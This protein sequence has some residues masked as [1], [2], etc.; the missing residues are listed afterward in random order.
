[1]ELFLPVKFHWYFGNLTAPLVTMML[2]VETQFADF[3]SFWKK[4][5]HF[6]FLNTQLVV[7]NLINIHDPIHFITPAPSIFKNKVTC[8]DWFG[9]VVG[10]GGDST[11]TVHGSG[12][13]HPTGPAVQL[14]GATPEIQPTKIHRTG[15]FWIK[16]ALLVIFTVK[17]FC[18]RLRNYFTFCF[19]GA[20]GQEL[21]SSWQPAFVLPLAR[22]CSHSGCGDWAVVLSWQPAGGQVGR[23]WCKKTFDWHFQWTLSNSWV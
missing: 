23:A 18:Q 19:A 17:Y 21:P 16:G 10:G 22:S 5:S 3:C 1:M 13:V 8:I 12:S 9:C 14:T 4:N 6:R 15:L 20:V 7:R 11:G 2:K